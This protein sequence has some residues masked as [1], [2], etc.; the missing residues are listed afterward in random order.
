[1][2]YGNIVSP[3]IDNSHDS[4]RVNIVS[5]RIMLLWILSCVRMYCE[6]IFW[7]WTLIIIDD[8]RCRFII[9]VNTFAAAFYTFFDFLKLYTTSNKLTS[10]FID[11]FIGAVR[12]YHWNKNE[13]YKS[14]FEMSIFIWLLTIRIWKKLLRDKFKQR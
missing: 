7:M 14:C 11:I 13:G 3:I 10:I 2:R 5:C 1:M 6:G 9:F 12:F 8:P 4:Q